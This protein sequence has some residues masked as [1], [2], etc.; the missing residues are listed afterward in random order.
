MSIAN[1]IRGLVPLGTF[2]TH[3]DGSPAAELEC[4]INSTL[5]VGAWPSANLGIFVPVIFPPC[6]LSTGLW[7][8][9]SMGWQP[10]TAS[11]NIDVGIYDA[12]GTRLYS[13]GSTAQSSASALQTVGPTL[14]LAG[15]LYYIGGAADNTTGTITAS[16]TG[17]ALS[18]R[19]CGVFSQASAFPLPSSITVGGAA[20]TTAYLPWIFCGMQGV[21]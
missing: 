17:S 9:R 5:A 13:A 21:L 7:P 4:S 6:P 19:L 2:S 15:G 12:S 20:P 8:L 16:T 1:P 18:L 14:N 10:T 3:G 11:G